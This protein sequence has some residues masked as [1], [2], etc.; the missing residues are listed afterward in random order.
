[1]RRLRQTGRESY[2]A[3]V[4]VSVD[5]HVTHVH[6]SL[7]SL[8]GIAAIRLQDTTELIKSQTF[9]EV[10]MQLSMFTKKNPPWDYIKTQKSHF[11]LT[12]PS[13]AL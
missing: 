1:M 4:G 6:D 10:S 13:T 8:V 12:F 5:S 11:P 2:I 9:R 3:L 7:E